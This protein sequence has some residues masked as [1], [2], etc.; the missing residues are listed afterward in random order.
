MSA[1]NVIAML[2][3]ATDSGT[4]G[5]GSNMQGTLPDGYL[6]P[7][8]VEFAAPTV[9]GPPTVGPDNQQ[10][11][12]IYRDNRVIPADELGMQGPFLLRQGAIA[13]RPEGRRFPLNIE[14]GPAGLDTSLP[15]LVPI[16]MAAILAPFSP[17]QL[18]AS[19]P[20]V[21]APEVIG[22][23]QTIYWTATPQ[24]GWQGY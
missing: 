24:V 17:G 3:G 10:Q 11:L 7:Y 14:Y 12:E 4:T 9:I 6:Q 13:K 5:L 1:P 20:G 18:P 22:P 8:S 2:T 19:Q 21:S 15:G 23:V 16:E